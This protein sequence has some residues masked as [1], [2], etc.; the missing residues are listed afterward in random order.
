[1]LASIPTRRELLA[2]ALAIV[3][4]VT[5][6][7]LARPDRAG[8]GANGPTTDVVY[9][10]T[11]HNFPDALSAAVTAAVGLGPVLLVEQNS[12]PAPTLTELNRLQPPN[13]VIVGGTA[14]ISNTVQT[15]LTGLAFS[16]TVTRVAGTNRY[17]TAAQLSA[18]T[19]PTSGRYPL[20][21]HAGGEQ[22]ESVTTTEEVMRSVS[23]T[24]PAAGTVIVN[25]TATGEQDVAG[26]GVRCSITTGTTIDFA[27]LQVWQ[28]PA[29]GF[30]MS[31]L[32]GTR[33]FDVTAGQTLTVNLVCQHVGSDSSTFIGD[34]ALTAI[35]VADH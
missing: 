30:A 17:D 14:V 1:M 15:Q 33:G 7:M 19:F 13:I 27:F 31:Q 11:G 21:V 16:P 12:I 10:A 23:L 35:F 29:N 6:V 34:S 22:D 5:A 20:A 9:I 8:A 3:M 4:T 2:W 28:T 24:A 26:D 25:S 18:A 32:S